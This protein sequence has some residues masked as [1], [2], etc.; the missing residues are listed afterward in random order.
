MNT[1]DEERQSKMSGRS[2][3][4]LAFVSLLLGS[5]ALWFTWLRYDGLM[6]QPDAYWYNWV[7]LAGIA[8]MG[9]LCLLAALSFILRGPSAQSLFKLGLSIVPII[10]F[11]NFVMFVFRVVQNILQGNANGF[12]ERVFTQPYKILLILALLLVLAVLGSLNEKRE[13]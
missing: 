1:Y 4:L 7:Q 11:T 10:L 2:P 12:F 3:G 8:L 5:G 6:N 13:Q 9:I